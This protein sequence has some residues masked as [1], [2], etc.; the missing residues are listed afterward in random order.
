MRK[1]FLKEVVYL[2]LSITITWFSC[3]LLGFKFNEYLTG[4]IFLVLNAIEI[5]TGNID[6]DYVLKDLGL[7]DKESDK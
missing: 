3:Q 6:S 5:S 4:L 7:I 1:R 2:V